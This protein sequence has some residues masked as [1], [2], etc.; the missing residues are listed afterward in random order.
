MS[1]VRFWVELVVDG[2]LIHLDE[3]DL[4]TLTDAQRGAMAEE[5]D[6]AV[7]IDGEVPLE[8]ADDLTA[9]AHWLCFAG[10]AAV[11]AD[12]YG[13]FLYRSTQATLH[14]VMIPLATLVRIFGEQTPVITAEIDE[15]FPALYHCGMRIVDLLERAGVPSEAAFTLDYLRT[16]ADELRTKLSARGVA[17]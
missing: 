2:T 12:P 16:A 11:L 17:V 10:P 6:G 13:C 9:V 7:V 8:V 3:D 5:I 15:L 14:T 4:A 1:R